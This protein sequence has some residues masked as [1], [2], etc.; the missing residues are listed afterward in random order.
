[1]AVYTISLSAKWALGL[2]C[3]LQSLLH[4][5]FTTRGEKH[6]VSNANAAHTEAP[7]HT[8]RIFYGL[9]YTRFIPC[10]LRVLR[11]LLFAGRVSSK[12]SLRFRFIEPGVVRTGVLAVNKSRSLS[13]QKLI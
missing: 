7:M 13:M 12:S 1:M 5:L 9:T 6:R 10:S 11:R 2:N 8:I 4:S 3:N